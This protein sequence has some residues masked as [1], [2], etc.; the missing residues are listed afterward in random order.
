MKIRALIGYNDNTY[1]KKC[2]FVMKTHHNFC[3]RRRHYGV[4][5]V[6]IM[7]RVGLANE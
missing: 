6:E 3:H 4:N 7:K 5:D 2:T 1:G